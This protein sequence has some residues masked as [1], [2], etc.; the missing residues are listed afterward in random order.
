MRLAQ[1]PLHFPEE[2]M[3]EQSVH[4]KDAVT[5]PLSTLN[6]RQTSA[7]ATG[8][9][10]MTAQRQVCQRCVM[11]SSAE[12]I[13]FDANGVCHFCT[14]FL[15]KQTPVLHKSDT[16][17]SAEMQELIDRIKHAG[18]RKRYDCIVGISGGIDSSYVLH[19]A[20]E[21]GLRPLAVHMDN[22]W[23]SEATTPIARPRGND[24]RATMPLP[25]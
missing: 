24:P 22:N 3:N 14:D 11:D 9:A 5:P 21:N 1:G 13:R 17:R 8:L 12:N 23:N 15:R 25:W 7:S 16:V 20:V 19:L 10:A 6:T 4:L 18:R 2:R